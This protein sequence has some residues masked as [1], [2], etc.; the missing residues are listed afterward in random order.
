[1]FVLPKD[2]SEEETE[3]CKPVKDFTAFGVKTKTKVKTCKQ[4]NEVVAALCEKKKIVKH[5][6]D[7]VLKYW[8]FFLVCVTQQWEILKARQPKSLSNIFN[9]YKGIM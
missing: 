9:C 2:G 7:S 3:V 5:V 6:K 8:L 4:N 1:M